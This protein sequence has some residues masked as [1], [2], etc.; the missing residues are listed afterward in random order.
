MKRFIV[1]LFLLLIGGAMAQERVVGRLGNRTVLESQLKGA[2]DAARA[3]QLRD[4]VVVPA[5]KAYLQPHAQ[6]LTPDDGE[7]QRFMQLDR[8]NRKCRGEPDEPEDPF[9][10]AWMLSNLKL[11]RYIYEQ[12]GGGR[13]RFQQMG[14]EAFDATR[15]MVLELERKG[16]FTIHSPE[17]RQLALSYWLEPSGPLMP[18]PGADKAL[19]I[20]HMLAPCPNR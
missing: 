10:A 4:M 9:A 18:D 15:N 1:C 13:L 8:E 19:K 14:T 6:R 2:T 11:Q 3:A 7:I 17:L 16:A 5:V 12:H 20:E